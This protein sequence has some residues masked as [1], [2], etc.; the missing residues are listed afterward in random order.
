[1]ISSTRIRGHYA[2][3]LCIMNWRTTPD[4][5]ARILNAIRAAPADD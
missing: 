5:V 1:M 3:R 2:L 4:D